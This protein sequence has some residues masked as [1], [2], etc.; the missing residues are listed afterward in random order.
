MPRQWRGLHFFEQYA[1]LLLQS[2]SIQPVKSNMEAYLN[3][4]RGIKY[5][6]SLRH[7][8]QKWGGI[9]VFFQLGMLTL[10]FKQLVFYI[11]KKGFI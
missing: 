6:H 5:A 3:I 10:I 9:G 1:C 8:S 11:S 2:K 4:T 7:T